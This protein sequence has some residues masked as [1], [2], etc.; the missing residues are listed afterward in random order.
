M[1]E[2]DNARQQKVD[3]LHSW[4]VVLQ[5]VSEARNSHL[6]CLTNLRP[7]VRSFYA[8]SLHQCSGLRVVVV[9]PGSQTRDLPQREALH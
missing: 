3:F 2:Y 9:T 6:T 8:P 7:K 5:N 1:I 4:A